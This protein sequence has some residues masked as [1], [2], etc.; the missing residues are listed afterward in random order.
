M[1]KEFEIIRE[2]E[3]PA[4]PAQVWDAITTGTGGWLWPMEYEPREGGAGP[5]GGT[6][7][8][9][10]PPRH[11][12]GRTEGP[13]GWFNQVENVI[14]ARDG[15]RAWLRYVHSG[16]FTDNW[17]TQYDGADKHTDFYLHTLAQYLEF[18]TGQHATYVAAD[19]PAASSAPGSFGVLRRELGLADG[20]EGDRVRLDIPGLP[21]VDG[22]VDYLRPQFLGI[23]AA[24]GLYRF[25]CR[26]AWGAPASVAVHLFPSE[27]STIDAEKAGQAW[28]D[29]LTALF[30]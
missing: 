20:A 7:T 23:R 29:W 4:T 12:I 18:F 11:L 17:D 21:V 14:E 16:I 19:G 5:F 2:S 10:D 1:A 27:P 22:V 15:G 6:V 8:R 30:T 9:W 24:D 26:D 13:D 28:R 3:L 25:F